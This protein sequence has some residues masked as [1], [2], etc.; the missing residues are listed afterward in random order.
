MKVIEAVVER[1]KEKPFTDV[2]LRSLDLRLSP[3]AARDLVRELEHGRF[4]I[5]RDMVGYIAQEMA[6]RKDYIVWDSKEFGYVFGF[7]MDEHLPGKSFVM[8]LRK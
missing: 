6:G 3:K 8:R 5:E 4:S 1:L 7:S 2:R